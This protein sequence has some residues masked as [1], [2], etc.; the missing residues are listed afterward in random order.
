MNRDAFTPDHI[1]PTED[2]TPLEIRWKDGH[3]S[4]VRPTVPAA[5]L[6][7]RRL[8]GRDDRPAHPHTRA[9]C[10]K[11]STP[12]PST[13]SV[14]TPSSSYGATGTTQGSIPSKP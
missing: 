5:Q 13:T 6:P 9:W 14:A 1:G 3:S 2:G 12:P 7:L 8:R 4:G 11:A 10:R